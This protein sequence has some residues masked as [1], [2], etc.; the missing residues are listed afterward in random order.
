MST[1]L[2]RADL[3]NQS[4]NES[5]EPETEISKEQK[6]NSS[7]FSPNYQ[8]PCSRILIYSRLCQQF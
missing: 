4:L 1:F 7:V 5:G 2:A 3:R 8:I 6:V